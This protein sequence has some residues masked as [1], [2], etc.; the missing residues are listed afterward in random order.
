MGRRIPKFIPQTRYTTIL[1]ALRKGAENATRDDVCCA[2]V[3]GYNLLVYGKLSVNV[4]WQKVVYGCA[5]TIIGEEM[6]RSLV[7]KTISVLFSTV[8]Y[9]YVTLN[10]TQRVR[11]SARP[12]VTRNW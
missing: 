7:A 6:H 3:C 4:D 1:S 10:Y 8:R 2:A 5:G 9:F 11:P 12:S